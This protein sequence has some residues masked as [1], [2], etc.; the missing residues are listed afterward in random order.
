MI[1][2][3]VRSTDSPLRLT[4]RLWQIWRTRPELYSI[5]D[6]PSF[7][8]VEQW[9][10]ARAAW[11]ELLS[12]K[13][14]RLLVV[15]HKS[16][17]RALVCAAL[18]LGPDAFRS[19]DLYNGSFVTFRCAAMLSLHI[20]DTYATSTFIHIAT[21]RLLLCVLAQLFNQRRA[22]AH[23]TECLGPSQARR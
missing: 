7:P 21:K 9:V 12:G 19:V 8:V 13:A 10:K 4:Q 5:G 16:I 20:H 6:P 18:G 22:A 11:A 1:S 15:T 2:Q 17:A 23:V 14:R 3:Y